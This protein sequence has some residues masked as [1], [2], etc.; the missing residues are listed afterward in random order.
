[1][2]EESTLSSLSRSSSRWTECRLIVHRGT[3]D[4]AWWSFLTRYGRGDLKWDRR[5][6]S[7]EL[8]LEPGSPE[9]REVV[10][11]LAAALAQLQALQRR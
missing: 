11:A 2:P 4:I 6:A 5:Q 3:G 8:R 10:A 7:G 9:S 1:M